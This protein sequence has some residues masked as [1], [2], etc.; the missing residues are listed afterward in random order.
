MPSP[1]A[2]GGPGQEDW[3]VEAAREDREAGDVVLVLVGN[4]NSVEP[5]WI[6]ARNGHTPEEFAAGEARVN[7]NAGPRAGDD[8]AVA[9]GAGGEHCH[10]HHSLRIR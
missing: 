7:Q 3:N 6:F 10:A 1:G 4:E 9:F 8:S 5:R 2:M